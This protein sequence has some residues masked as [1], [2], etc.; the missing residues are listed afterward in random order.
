MLMLGWLLGGR[1]VRDEYAVEVAKDP[2][3][4]ITITLVACPDERVRSISVY[5]ESSG[6]V[7]WRASAREEA[8]PRFMFDVTSGQEVNG[9]AVET[10]AATFP[11][12]ELVIDV[13]LEDGFLV[14]GEQD[15]SAMT[16]GVTYRDGEPRSSGAASIE[17]C[18]R[19]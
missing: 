14:L 4:T 18:D 15:F 6:Q 9:Y 5:D 7:Y 8:L 13:Y 2:T 3:G 12:E 19:P 17:G 11:E 16:P 10:E 1:G